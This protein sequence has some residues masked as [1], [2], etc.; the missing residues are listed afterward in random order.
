MPCVLYISGSIGLGHAA[1]DLAIADQLRR[2]EPA[3]E[4]DWLAGEPARGL[5]EGTGETVLPES[6]AFGETDF[7]EA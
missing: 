6:A 7:A 5:I 1:R 4:I 3:I 2:L